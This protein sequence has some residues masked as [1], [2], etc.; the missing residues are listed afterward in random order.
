MIIGVPKEI[1]DQE[2]R[3]GITPAGVK[4]LVK[5]GHQVAVEAGAGLGSGINDGDYAAA[6]GR[7]LPSA[8]DVYEQADMI[9]KVK[10]PLPAE[11]DLLKEG[12]LLFTFLHLAPEPELTN[13]LLRK[14]ISGVA[15]ETIQT[16]WGDLPLLIPMSE[17]AGRMSVQI[18]AQFLEKQYGGRGVLLGGVPGVLPG[19]VTIIG[20]GTV[21]INA[22]KVAAG[23]G[24]GVTILD[25]NA[26]RLRYLDDI[27][28]GRVK[29]Y[30]SN[31][32]HIMEAVKE[33]DLLVGAVLVPGART[34]KLVTADMVEEMKPGSVIVDVAIDQ[35]GCV[36]TADRVTTHSNPVYVKYGVIHYAVANIP[37]TV[38]RTSTFALTNVTLPYALALADKGLL[39]AV[40]DDIAL[41][42]GVNVYGGNITYKA[43]A[44][45]LNL[46]YTPPGELMELSWDLNVRSA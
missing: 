7:I 18:G 36:E 33:A 12:Q 10:E 16:D 28:G 27:F 9:M 15:Y 45:S 35:G 46:P 30:M 42:K 38:A 2:Y 26:G 13:M 24:A 29:T 20:G 5:H 21:G 3:V 40:K 8:G 4:A 11:Y 19:K 32:Y 23:M 22:A 17:V 43:V 41:A 39:R 31:S 14:K 1:K 6:G 37:G 44:E 34:P 25:N